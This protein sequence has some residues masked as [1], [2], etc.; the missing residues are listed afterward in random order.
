MNR[1]RK[2]GDKYQVLYT[3]TWPENPSFEIIMGNWTDEH[4][5]GYYVRDFETLGDAQCEAFNYPDIPWDIMVTSYKNSFYDNK[6]I[7]RNI[8]DQNKFIVEFEAKFMDQDMVKNAMFN[9]VLNSGK[10]FTLAYG[11]NDIVSY[12]IINPWSKNL[13]EISQRLIE[14]SRLKIIKK[15]VSNGMIHL[16]GKN[17]LG[18]TYEIALWPTVIH[19]W[20]KWVYN[21]PEVPPKTSQE[22]YVDAVKK[23]AHIDAG[24]TLR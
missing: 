9:R 10:R 13:L 6:K 14:N 20:A 8:L 22:T 3:P 12:H 23:Q 15:Y 2:Y 7:I 16:I 17:D 4:L 18:T 5:R 24:F 1:I 21:H 19:Q 11:M